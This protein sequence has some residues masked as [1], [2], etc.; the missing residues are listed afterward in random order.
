MAG[1]WAQSRSSERI[2]ASRMITRM[3]GQD[4]SYA[5]LPCPLFFSTGVPVVSS[6]PSPA[7]SHGSP[8][9][10]FRDLP[11][12]PPH[13]I[14]RVE[15][16]PSQ[17]WRRT[18]RPSAPSTRRPSRRPSR[19]SAPSSPRRA[20]PRSCSASRKPLL[21]ACSSTGCSLRGVLGGLIWALRLYRAGGTPLGRSMCRPRPVAPSGR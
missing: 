14:L 7:P 1:Q 2:P 8:P 6:P 15:S 13:R 9:H 19:S 11:S 21:P 17:P 4:A 20:A 16:L 3:D 18:T 5:N 12:P 10:S